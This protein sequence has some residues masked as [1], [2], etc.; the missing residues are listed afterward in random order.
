M[1]LWISRAL[2]SY[3][4]RFMD[5]ESEEQRRA[6]L[7][8]ILARVGLDHFARGVHGDLRLTTR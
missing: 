3:G 2:A 8:S 1:E 6:N 7:E 5:E 4:E